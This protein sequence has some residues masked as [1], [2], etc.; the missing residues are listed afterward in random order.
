MLQEVSSEDM[1]LPLTLLLLFGCRAI[2]GS[3]GD[4]VSLSASAPTLD[5]EEKYSAHM[6]AHLRCDACRAVAFQVSSACPPAGLAQ[7]TSSVVDLTIEPSIPS[8][9]PE[10]AIFPGYY[11]PPSLELPCLSLLFCLV[12]KEQTI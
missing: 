4:R 7:A 9:Q 10:S 6:P 2:L 3:A 5:D 1:R 8:P 11:Q 12:T